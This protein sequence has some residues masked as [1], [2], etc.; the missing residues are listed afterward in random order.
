MVGLNRS[1]TWRDKFPIPGK[2]TPII[3]VGTSIRHDRVPHMKWLQIHN[4]EH[5][6][7]LSSAHIAQPWHDHAH[8]AAK[9]SSFLG[10]VS[11]GHQH[12]QSLVVLTDQAVFPTHDRITS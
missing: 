5:T 1:V 6:S 7:I 2:R 4:M 11:Q 8:P 9:L 10:K 3:N 12:P